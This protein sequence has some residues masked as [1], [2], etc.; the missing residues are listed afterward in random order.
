MRALISVSNKDGIIKFATELAEMGVEIISTGGTYKTLKDAGLDVL[1]VAEITKFRECLDGRVKTLH[2][3]IHAGILNV[4]DDQ[5]HQQQM[6]EMNFQNIDFVIVNLYPFRETILKEDVTLAEAIENIDIGGPTMLRSAAKNSKD[7][8]V[9]VDPADYQTVVDQMKET[10]E[11]SMATKAHLAYKVFLHTANYDAMIARFL[12]E[13]LES[14]EA[15]P[16]KL[17][18]TFE[19]IQ[20]MRYGENPHQKAAFYKEIGYTKGTLAN[21]KQINGKALSYNNINDANGALA[22]LREFDTTAVVAVKHATPCGVGTANNI[23]DAYEKAYTSDP[24]SIF[25]GIVVCNDEV[26]EQTATKMN[27]IFLEIIIAPSYTAEAKKLFKK[28][29]NLRVLEL[30]D[31]LYSHPHTLDMKK[32]DGGLIIQEADRCLFNDDEEFTVVTKVA[33]TATQIED[34]KFAWKIVK[35]VKS[36]AITLAKNGMS[37]GIGGGQVNRIWATQQA[38]AHAEEFVGGAKGAVLASDAFF[39]FDDCAETAINAGV[40]A[41]IQPGGSIRDQD[42]IDMCDKHG[43]AMVFTGMRHFKH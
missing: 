27:E 22:L 11:V 13:Q 28:K 1:E 5:H 6:K 15:F 9:V 26:D 7:V 10:N 34:L 23:Y 14:K 42:S 35:H 43:I 37:V 16:E 24:V 33:P 41:I 18:L 19:K 4:R 20:D 21:A 17:T 25:G 30:P 32:I 39:P 12:G 40:V 36:N 31:I 3:L 29:K 2:P 8:V 38:I